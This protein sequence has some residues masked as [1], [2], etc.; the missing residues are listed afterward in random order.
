MPDPDSRQET[1]SMRS[2]LSLGRLQQILGALW[3]VDGVLQLQPVMF[4]TYL[5]NGLLQPLT[6]GQPAPIAAALQAIIQIAGQNLIAVNLTIAVVQLALGICLLSGAFVRPALLASV[7][8]SLLV[9]FGGEGLGMLLTG[10]AG[11]LTGAP[12][13]VLLYLVLA[14]AAYPTDGPSDDGLLSRSRLRLVLAGFWALTAALQ[15]QPFWWQPQQISN[16]IA[17]NV[18][19][20]TLNGTLLDPL[21]QGL[22][23]LTARWELPLNAAIIAVALGLAVGLAVVRTDRVR[24]LLAVSIVLSLLLWVAGEGAGQLL[25]GSATDFNS[26]LP[27]AILALASFPVL[28]PAPRIAMQGA[29]VARRVRGSEDRS[30]DHSS[31]LST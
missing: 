24:P 15:L 4:T 25:S 9:W 21:L 29:N 27:L 26:G 10:Q 13:A 7:V 23:D 18:N 11:A 8:W 3:L 28:Q 14:L 12:G 22:A 1:G 31:G 17:A 20:G 30:I 6:Q 19:P 5:T 16:D 2:F